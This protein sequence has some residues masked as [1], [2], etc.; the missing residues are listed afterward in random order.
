MSEG[1]GWIWLF[2]R[3]PSTHIMEAASR[4]RPFD[5]DTPVAVKKRAVSSANDSP[6]AI[7]S[8]SQLTEEPRDENEL[9][10][11]ALPPTFLST[12]LLP[13]R[14]LHSTLSAS[15]ES[16]WARRGATIMPLLGIVRVWLADS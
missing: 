12:F 7:P 8:P 4:K 10:V 16:H 13:S 6:V 1:L 11:R 2:Q 9:E 3:L 5:G 15:N 14:D